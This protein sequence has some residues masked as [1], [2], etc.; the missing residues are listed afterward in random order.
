[1]TIRLTPLILLWIALLPAAQGQSFPSRPISL[2]CPFPPGSTSDLIPRAV[3]PL[4][5]EALGVPVVV[6]NR[7]GAGG[8]IGAAYAAKA[9]PDGHTVLMAPTPVLAINQ[10]LYKELPY[11][12]EKDFVP[13]T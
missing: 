12:P 11:S 4:M 13:I 10:W 7:P 8:S 6:E 2:V 1:M 5:S 9:K 3:A